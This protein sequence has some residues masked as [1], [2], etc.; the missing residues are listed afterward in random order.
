MVMHGELCFFRGTPKKKQTMQEEKNV[1]VPPEVVAEVVAE[2]VTDILV[3]SLAKKKLLEIGFAILQ[4]RYRNI[5]L[6]AVGILSLVFGMVQHTLK[7]TCA[8]RLSVWLMVT[9]AILICKYLVWF[10]INKNWMRPCDK[11]VR[12]ANLL[13]ALFICISVTAGIF[14]LAMSDSTCDGTLFGM[15]LAVLV[16]T[17]G[18]VLTL[19]L[20][21]KCL[22]WWMATPE[23]AEVDQQEEE[24][25]T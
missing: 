7:D 25:E 15:S 13:L 24:D 10:V 16:L 6:C 20:V 23:A 5:C 9:G 11:I 14:L 1:S 17:V 2:V 18:G 3:S 8:T 19:W 22:K 4:S 12:F 21:F